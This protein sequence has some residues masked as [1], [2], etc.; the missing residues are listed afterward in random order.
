MVELQKTLQ[1]IP[2][3]SALTDYTR[4]ATSA[5]LNGHEIKQQLEWL[6]EG[7]IAEGRSIILE[8]KA[9]FIGSEICV[10]ALAGALDMK[11]IRHHLEGNQIAT[12]DTDFSAS[13]NNEKSGIPIAHIMST[14]DSIKMLYP[15][16]Y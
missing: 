8:Q 14:P 15:H 4:N 3:D 1:L 2:F 6:D 11:I 12:D 13:Y 9:E 7:T 5:Y 10:I 16:A